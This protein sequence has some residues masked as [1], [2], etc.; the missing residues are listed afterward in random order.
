MSFVMGISELT[1]NNLRNAFY[2]G[3]KIMGVRMQRKRAALAARKSKPVEVEDS[4]FKEGSRRLKKG[5]KWVSGEP[6]K[7]VK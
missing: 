4:P 1:P 3:R 5:W 2:N 7:V 6:V